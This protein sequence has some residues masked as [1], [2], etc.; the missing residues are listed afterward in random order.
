VVIW[1]SLCTQ[2]RHSSPRQSHQPLAPLAFA[3]EWFVHAT[4]RRNVRD[5]GTVKGACA[6]AGS[7]VTESGVRIPPFPP[8]NQ[9][10]LPHSPD[11]RRNSFWFQKGLKGASVL[12]RLRRS[13]NLVSEAPPS[14]SD[15]TSVKSVRSENIVECQ[16]LKN[17]AGPYRFALVLSPSV[18]LE[19]AVRVQPRSSAVC[20]NAQKFCQCAHRVSAF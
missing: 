2:S 13:R 8:F 9:C 5:G 11:E 10:K 20:K 7:T 12:L 18:G 16:K 19:P 1:S 4:G 14:H 6:R 17:S 15:R 3:V